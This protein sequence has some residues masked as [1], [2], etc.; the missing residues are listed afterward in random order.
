MTLENEGAITF[1]E[2][3]GQRA[4]LFIIVK[5]DGGRYL[6]EIEQTLNEGRVFITDVY[7]ISDW[8]KVA[9]S[10]YQTQL[11]DASRSFRVGFESHVWL[12]QY[13]FG[14]Q[15]LLLLLN[16]QAVGPS[17]NL[18][19]KAVYEARTN[20]RGKFSA[21]SN[22][23][24]AIAVNLDKFEKDSFRGSGKKKGHLGISQPGSFDPLFDGISRGRWYGNYFKYMHAPENSKELS[25]QFQALASLDIMTEEN[26]VDR[27]EWEILK[28]IHC[29]LPPSKYIRKK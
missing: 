7:A 15:A 17:C 2:R 6:N 14:N 16:A 27:E 11:Q 12:C 5:P 23:T 4:R 25:F 18:Q 9:R 13:L 29:L 19:A 10:I 21:A 1:Q 8:E 26:K 24:I 20:F 3:E 28:Q 22:G